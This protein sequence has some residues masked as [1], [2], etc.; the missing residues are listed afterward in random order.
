[1]R[2]PSYRC[3]SP[4]QHSYARDIAGSARTDS[5]CITDIV[6]VCPCPS[7]HVTV[8]AVTGQS[9]TPLLYKLR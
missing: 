1:M 3:G 6:R 7:Q 9:V 8:I 5:S 4:R 2:R